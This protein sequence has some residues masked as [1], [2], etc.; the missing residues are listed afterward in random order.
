MIFARLATCLQAKETKDHRDIA[1]RLQ[2]DG[3][4]NAPLSPSTFASVRCLRRPGDHTLQ[5]SRL[6]TPHMIYQRPGIDTME[7]D[8]VVRTWVAAFTMIQL[9]RHSSSLV[10]PWVILLLIYTISHT[11]TLILRHWRGPLSHRS[12]GRRHRLRPDNEFPLLDSHAPT[13]PNNVSAHSVTPEL[14]IKLGEL[15]RRTRGLTFTITT[16]LQFRV[17]ITAFRKSVTGNSQI[18]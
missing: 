13:R 18:P 4:Q 16:A 12:H 3:H 5:S 14:P 9:S 15:S 1:R 10:G 7:R 8:W 2:S 17:T 11:T 6:F